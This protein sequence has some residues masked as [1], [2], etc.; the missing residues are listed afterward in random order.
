MSV[1]AS[2]RLLQHRNFRRL[3]IGRTASQLGTNIA[4][5]ALVFGLLGLGASA[6]TLGLV[7]AANTLPQILLAL[8][9]GVIGD[10]F[11]RR[12]VLIATDVVQGS[13]QLL[14]GVLFITGHAAVWTVFALRFLYGSAA[15]FFAPAMNGAIVDVVGTDGMQEARSLLSI[16][17]SVPR[18]VGPAIGGLLVAL[19]NPGWALVI[20][21]ATFAISAVNL[22]LLHMPRHQVP[23]GNSLR[24][25]FVHGW[26]EF[27]SRTWAVKMIASF[28][29]YQAT[30]LPAV[31]VLGPVHAAQAWHGA[32]SWAAVMSAIAVGDVLGGVIMLRWKPRRLLVA[33]NLTWAL[34][35]PLLFCIGLQ[36][37]APGAAVVAAVGFGLAMTMGG[38]LWYQALASNVPPG[39][40]SR[41]TSYD[42]VGSIALNPLGYMLI[43]IVAS[44]VGI[45]GTFTFVIGSH[46][47]MLLWLLMSRDVRAI[48][49]SDQAAAASAPD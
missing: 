4:L 31:F 2:L 11:E 1:R 37:G 29:L 32:S 22:A 5:L 35:L 39:S 16:G 14:I 42:E 23:L 3:L 38:V 41:V 33:S 44:S 18:V 40:L 12:R 19:L 25:D 15:A 17:T 7:M 47:L 49:R 36:L 6:A 43:G 8:L 9:G 48:G 28:M 13:V 24:A 26:R 30:A 10:R 46:V 45:R 34:D 20:D 21:S 27:T